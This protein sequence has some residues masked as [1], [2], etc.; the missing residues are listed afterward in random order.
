[1]KTGGMRSRQLG[2]LRIRLPG[3]PTVRH[4]V[5][6]F[7][8]VVAGILVALGVD[9]WRNGREELNVVNQHLADVTDEVRQNLCTVQRIRMRAVTEK[10]ANLQVVLNFLNDP[11]APVAEPAA[12]LEAFALSSAR[13]RPWLVDNQY[14]ALQ[15]S[16][17][18]RLV[19]R[20][21]PDLQLAAVYE[22]P[23]VLFAQVDRL[24]GD[25]PVI[26]NELIPAQLQQHDNAL[27][28]YALGA[29]APA[30]TDDAD[31]HAAI[32]RIRGRRIELLDLARNEAAVTTAT[33]YVLIRVKAEMERLLAQLAAWDRSQQPVQ[34]MLTECA[35]PRK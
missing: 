28:K 6:E 1:M 20:L 27:E 4:V 24:Q 21:K 9:Q 3:A 8:I 26:V 11:S 23:G 7:L 18:V 2:M 25:Y 16:G 19:R 5:T 30:F 17:N 32:E 14:Q 29:S 35:A 31:L 22:A 13:S 15:N 34:D 33:W 10:Q 12:L